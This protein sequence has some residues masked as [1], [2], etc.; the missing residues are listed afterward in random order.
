MPPHPHPTSRLEAEEELVSADFA[1]FTRA[2]LV[3]KF[4]EHR[5]VIIRTLSL[6]HS[7]VVGLIYGQGVPIPVISI[8]RGARNAAI[9]S[10]GIII[11]IC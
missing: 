3:N 4:L 7:E 1:T 5:L 9:V 10:T 11:V 2:P 8:P 6:T